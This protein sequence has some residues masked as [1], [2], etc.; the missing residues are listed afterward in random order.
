MNNPQR[1]EILACPFRS[2]IVT[3]QPI[4]R[5]IAAADISPAF[6]RRVAVKKAPRRVNHGS[7][8]SSQN[9]RGGHIAY[10][11]GLNP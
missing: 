3:V 2:R 6:Q 5:R 9:R 11:V 10:Y 4:L 7:N 1:G 8:Q